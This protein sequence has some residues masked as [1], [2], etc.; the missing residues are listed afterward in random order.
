M[1]APPVQ[2]VRTSD[3]YDIAYS[4]LGSGRSFLTAPWPHSHLQLNGR[5]GEHLLLTRELSARFRLVQYD[6]RGQGLSTRHLPSDLSCEG[7]LRD[8][9]AVVD[10]LQLESFV[11]YGWGNAMGH[12]ALLYAARHPERVDGLILQ[13]SAVHASAWP[14]SVFVDL[15]AQNWEYYLRLVAR[16]RAEGSRKLAD[17][18]LPP[19]DEELLYETLRESVDQ[20]DWQLTLKAF[21]DSDVSMVLP[22]LRAPTLVLHQRDFG[23]LPV[24]HAVKLAACIPNSHL[25]LLE[26][27][28]LHGDLKQF[29]GAVDDFVAS[30]PSHQGAPMPEALSVRE[31]EV[32]RLLAAG[33]SNQQIADELVISRNTVRRHVSNIF[34]KIGAANR[35]LATAYARDHGLA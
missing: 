34:D 12:I 35:V 10:R 3:G 31:V 6:A 11:L 18:S 1:D 24:E 32:L 22:K 29:L 5:S 15:S 21:F 2:Y 25:V 26:G 17:P 30:L 23:P 8:M 20:Q 28:S 27:A 19:P 4:V 13:C 14:G 9:E 16:A 7:F 33:R